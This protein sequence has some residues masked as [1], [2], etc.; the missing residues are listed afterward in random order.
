MGRIA[1][2]V[3]AGA[4]GAL[5][6]AGLSGCLVVG[7]SSESGWWVWPGSV[8][9]TLGLVALWWLMRRH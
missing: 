9:V 6:C 1:K 3:V 5:A 8:I 2:A 7:Y 4:V